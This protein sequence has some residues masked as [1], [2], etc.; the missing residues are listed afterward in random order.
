MEKTMEKWDVYDINK[1]KIGKVHERGK[2]LM[3]G[4][5]HLT[6]EVW[7]VDSYNRLL[8]SQRHPSRNNGLLW[9]CSGGSVLVDEDSLDGAQREC[10]EELG[11]EINKQLF[12]YVG[13]DIRRDYI[14]DTYVA[15]TDI[16]CS[17]IKMQPEEVVGVKYVTLEE[18]INLGKSGKIVQ[19][20]WERF[21]KYQK[22]IMQNHER[23]VDKR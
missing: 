9:E 7:I 23:L 3:E 22:N 17:D 8:I 13:S 2:P 11:I 10:K 21:L 6:V 12:K 15:Y 18:M 5:Y 16:C 19:S 20:T 4:E 1:V 14:L